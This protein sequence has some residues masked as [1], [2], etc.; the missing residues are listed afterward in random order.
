MLDQITQVLVSVEKMLD[1]Y[2]TEHISTCGED[3]RPD[4]TIVP[5]EKMLDQITQ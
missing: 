4:N 5:V 2:N 1:Q 3:V